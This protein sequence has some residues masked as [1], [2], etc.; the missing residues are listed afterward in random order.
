[1][2]D[3][4]VDPRG[5]R[6]AIAREEARLLH[7]QTELGHAQARLAELKTT[8]AAHEGP[9]E[10]SPA[11]PSTALEKIALFR[12]RFRGRDDI[13]PRFWSNARTGRKGYAPACGNEWIRG[14]CEKPRVKCGECSNQ[15]FLPVEDKVI[16]D[17]LQGRHVVGV[18]PLLTDD[19]SWFL[20][21]DFDKASWTD[22]VA[23]FTET[24]RTHGLPAAVE[25][26][27]SGNGAHVWFFFSAPMAASA[28]RQL[29]CYL[30]TETMSRRHQLSMGSY[31]RLFPNQDTLPRGGFGNLIALPLQHGPRQMGNTVFVD[32]QFVPHPDQWRFLSTHPRIEPATVESL[33]REATRRGLVVGVRLSDTS[34]SE[35]SE[36]W[37]RRPSGEPPIR[38]GAPLPSEVCAVLAQR[39][40]VAK[41]GLAPT[42]L[43]Q[44]KRLAAFQNPEFYKK[45]SLRLSTALTPRV[46]ACAEDLLE[47][48]AVPRG[49]QTELEQVLREYGSALLVEDRRCE[50][51]P[52][53]VRFHG[54]LTAV[55]RK[56]V[57]A[58]RR[59]D[60][61][62]LVAPPGVGK[63]VIGTY[64]I[65]ARSR[66]TLVLVHRQP[67]LDQWV[68]QLS[69]F[70]GVAPRDVGQ[71]GAGKHTATGRIDVAM[72]QSLV[73]SA[74]VDDLVATYGHVIVDEC[75]HIPAAS[76]ERVLGEV[77]ARFI[78]GLTATPRRRDGLHPIIEM[79]LGPGRFAVDARS[80]AVR[81][82]FEQQLIVRETAFGRDRA[83]SEE[84]IQSL[85]AELATDERRN[86]LILEDVRSALVAGRSPILLTERK[87]HL[88]L[89]V[90]G[91]QSAARHVIILRGGMTPTERRAAAATLASIPDGESRLLIATGRYI[92]EGFD[93]ARLDTLFLAMPISWKGTL[94]QYA[95][96][97]HRLHP[98]KTEVRIYDYVDRDVPMLARMFKKR[99]RG[100][101]AIGYD[102]D[103]RPPRLEH[104]DALDTLD[105]AEPSDGDE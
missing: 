9:V 38:F 10:T 93:D 19:T 14:V 102:R 77:K 24:C 60:I 29:G 34:D 99:L 66:N 36:P 63:T 58:L 84:R 37:M 6:D 104:D 105:L 49:C 22:D 53:N 23:A 88:E 21:A 46:I 57:R 89:L 4:F 7:L 54:Q 1:M 11:A 75:H 18:Y 94:V 67:L 71:I 41:G 70:L 13:Y 92:G 2:L 26:S 50:G 12:S 8:L 59:E 62:V 82:P 72:I 81:R 33:S 61:G 30:I 45:Q 56:A 51:Q 35:A 20:A 100:Y 96:R 42:H 87:D 28:A 48:V 74:R 32:N 39:L 25:R 91:L 43:N 69:M 65:A 31:D 76:F 78:I 44:I 85:Y 103:F 64:L 55:Q 101:H 17:H 3:P 98:G 52:L 83:V 16:L 15:A 79:Q 47:Y 5:L 86:H 68:A 73:R 80:Q 40:F 90:A 97:L 95:G 27:R